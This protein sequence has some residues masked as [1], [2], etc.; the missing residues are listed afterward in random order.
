V[1][2]LKSDSITAASIY[3]AADR[4]Q[5]TL[6]I[7]GRTAPAAHAGAGDNA[8]RLLLARSRKGQVT[9]PRRWWPNR[10]IANS[11]GIN[12]AHVGGIPLMARHR[13]T[14][15]GERPCPSPRPRPVRPARRQG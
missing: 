6:L 7:D 3:H 9:M 4:E 11:F 10:W 2:P 12:L 5:P 1:R 15:T 14:Y 13:K 8:E